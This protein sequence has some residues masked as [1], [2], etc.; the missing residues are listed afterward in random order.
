MVPPGEF[1]TEVTGKTVTV[2]NTRFRD[3][4]QSEQFLGGGRTLWAAGEAGC[5]DGVLTVRDNALC[6]TYPEAGPGTGGCWWVFRDRDGLY[7]RQV[8]LTGT[9]LEVIEISQE[10]LICADTPMS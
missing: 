5:H 8:G 2:A 3:L 9:V 6:F 7:F 1:L 4:R 10:P